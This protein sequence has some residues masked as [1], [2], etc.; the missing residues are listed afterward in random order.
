MVNKTKK[1]FGKKVGKQFKSF[2]SFGESPTFSIDGGGS[3]NSYRGAIVSIFISVITLLFAYSRFTIMLEF[4][5][6]NHQTV[7]QLNENNGEMFNQTDS[8]F[9][10]AFQLTGS[11]D[12]DP[13]DRRTG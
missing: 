13:Y 6:T 7:T 12:Y 5:D 11:S 2:D 9:N 8:N 1:S 10:I 4:D 3:F